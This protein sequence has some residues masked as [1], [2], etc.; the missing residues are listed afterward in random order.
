MSLP[1]QVY[2][3]NQDLNLQF[4]LIQAVIASNSITI[5]LVFRYSTPKNLIVDTTPSHIGLIRHIGI[6]IAETKKTMTIVRFNLSNI[7][8][9]ENN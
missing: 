5:M 7:D 6:N 1:I 8:S 4:R 3:K 2:C 9:Q